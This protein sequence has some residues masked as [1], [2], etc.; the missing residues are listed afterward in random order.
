[1][2]SGAGHAVER[3]SITLINSNY[4]RQ[5]QLLVRLRNRDGYVSLSDIAGEEN[6]PEHVEETLESY[7]GFKMHGVDGAHDK[8]EIARMISTMSPV[9]ERRLRRT[10]GVS[11]PSKP[12]TSVKSIENKILAKLRRTKPKRPCVW[13]RQNIEH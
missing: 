11:S 1:V 10:Y 9:E 7:L 4:R 8:E 2:L 13:T 12:K 3:C 6:I 5:G